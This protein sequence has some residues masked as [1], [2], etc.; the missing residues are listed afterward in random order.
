MS[1]S[2]SIGTDIVSMPYH[3]TGEENRLAS[4]DHHVLALERIPTGMIKSEASLVSIPA[5]AVYMATIAAMSP[6]TPT[7][8][9]HAGEL[10]RYAPTRHQ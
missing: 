1:Q 9:K 6:N 5:K 2:R 8:F 4:V 7:A 10:P 3:R